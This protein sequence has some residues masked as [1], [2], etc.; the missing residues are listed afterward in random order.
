MEKYLFI[1]EKPSLMRDVQ[2]CYKK[3]KQEVTSKVGAMDFIAL[4]GHVC[5]NNDPNEYEEWKDIAWDDV[6]YPMVPKKW[7][8]SPINDKRKKE[9]LKEIKDSIDEYDGIVVGTDSDIE[10]YGIYYLLEQYLGI[11]DKKAIRFIE[12]SLTDEEILDSLLTMKDY[13]TDPMHVRNTQAYIIR[14]RADWLYGMNGT[15]KESVKQGEIMTVGRVKSVTIKLVYDNSMAI[16]NFVSKKYWQVEADYGSFTSSLMDEDGKIAKFDDKTKIGKYPLDGVVESIETEESK[17]HAPK[18]YD[19]AA[20]QVDAGREFGYNPTKTLDILQSL[21]EKHKVISYPRTQCRYISKEKSKEFPMMLSHMD[22]FEEFAPYA[23][24]IN[25]SDI[26]R[27]QSDKQVVNDAEVQKESHDALLPTSKRPIL[28]EMNQEEINVC[29]MIFRRLLAQFLPIGVDNKTTIVTVHGDG[30]F[31][32]NG[33]TVVVQGWRDL[34]KEALDKTLPPLNKGENIKAEKI[35][36]VEKK[37]T[38][39]K[40]LTEVSLLNAMVNVADLIEDKDL[41]K[42]LAESKGIGTP[43][44][45]AKIIKDILEH[46]YVEDKKGSLY[47]T[48]LGKKYIKAIENLDIISPVFAA[49]MDTEMKKVQRGESDYDVVYQNVL[50]GVT[51]MC[52]QIDTSASITNATRIKCPVCGGTIKVE[53]F[54]YECENK[55]F[56]I[57][58]LVCGKE[59]DQILLEKLISGEKSQTFTF[60]KKDGKKFDAKLIIVDNKLSFDFSVPETNCN[61]PVC[62]KKLK[63]SKYYYECESQD[64]KIPRIVC[65]KTIDEKLLQKLLDGEK[66]SKYTFK[67]KDGTTF[68][69]RLVIVD[70]EL[71]FDFSSGIQCP[72]CKEKEVTINKAGAF[73]DCGLKIFRNMAKHEFTDAELKEILTK[74]VLKGINDFVGSNGS[75]FS[76][77]VVIG[78]DGTQQFL[79]DSSSSGIKCPLCGQET[80]RINKGGAFCE[81]GLKLFRNMAK[82]EFTDSELKSILS[83]GKTREINDFES[84]SGKTFSAKVILQDDGSLKFEFPS[85]KE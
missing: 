1:A 25:D 4:A 22:V 47:I 8:V 55:D 49:V 7:L 65:G 48:P 17:T 84:K 62:G 38:P 23:K 42:S 64:F 78:E 2:A 85:K 67:K 79:F 32:A 82:H 29:Q 70:N 34:Y 16:D 52:Q 54:K 68:P 75:K 31:I 51:D 37:T 66:S 76:A 46:G 6:E 26:K 77:S 41:K 71:K 72:R 50:K 73:C 10:G 28:S 56:D 58:K 57:P 30:R 18:L 81:C 45:R 36:T 33:K 60:K 13:H 80:V 59:I 20:A 61:C 63:A 3:H 9:I 83:K 24:K 12:H 27:V 44:T 14:S 43:A 40:R 11:Q 35:D 39:P 5:R 19:L 69:A 53:R 15:R 74:G 21:Y